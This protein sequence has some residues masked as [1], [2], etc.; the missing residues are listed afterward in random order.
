MKEDKTKYVARM[1]DTSTVWGQTMA[2]AITL[3]SVLTNLCKEL[4]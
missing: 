2:A 4:H 1:G 3:F